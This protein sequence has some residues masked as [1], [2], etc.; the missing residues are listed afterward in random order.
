MK[1]SLSRTLTGWAP[2]DDEALRVSRH[3]K[4]GESVVVDM[5]RPR[6]HRTLR[7]YWGLCK[8]I[9]QNSEDFRSV[10][11]VSDYLKLRAGHC[12]SIASESTGEVFQIPDSIDYDSLDEPEF[13]EVWRRVV[14]VVC[15]D[16]LPGMTMPEVEHEVL[17][18]CGLAGGGR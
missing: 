3:W 11:Q 10:T 1:I 15:E 17:K 8:L 7:R 5:K 14:D 9:L 16:F 4:P 13:Q 2:A 18:C 12:S 6:Q